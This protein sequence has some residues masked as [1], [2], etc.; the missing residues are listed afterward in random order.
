MRKVLFVTA[1][2][3]AA[4]LVWVSLTLPPRQV[5]LQRTPDGTV[6]GILHVH[7]SRS[8]GRSTPDEIAAAAARA[9]LSFVVF[10]DHGDGTR[11]P[12]PP[13]Y[14]S[15][16]LCVDGVEISTTGGHYIA[17]EMTSAP[18]PLGGEP[19][20]VIDDVRRLG[21]FG[22]VA[23]PDS[24]KAALQWREWTAPFDALEWLNPDTSWRQ[25]SLMPGW[26]SRAA[27]VLALLHYP[28]RPQETI[29]Q[30][31][32]GPGEILRWDVLTRRRRVVALAGV[33]A[34]AKL[35]LRNTD[36]GDNRYTLPLPGY[37]ATFRTLSVHV[38]TE[39][40]LTR[41]A[42]RDAA[43][44]MR[45][46]RAGHAYTAIDA[47]ASPPFFEFSATNDLGTVHEGDELGA[48]GPVT[49]AVR[50][51][52][53]VGFATVIYK[54]G[55]VLQTTTERT[56]S[57]QA[58]PD[59]AVY[60]VEIQTPGSRRS[61]PS[62]WILSNPVYVRGPQPSAKLAD[63]LPPTTASPLPIG[64]AADGWRIENYAGHGT[65]ERS[66]SGGREL[67]LA[68]GLDA[69]PV[70]GQYVA[71]VFDTP[72]GIA[73]N[74]RLV[75]TARAE[76]PM[77]ISV[78]LRVPADGG[79]GERWQRSVYV[80]SFDQERTVYFDDVMP[81]GPTETWKPALDRV[82]SVMFVIDTTNTRPGST[83]RLT[84][85]NVALAQ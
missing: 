34:H 50:S 12:D 77:R 54:D 60:R 76:R 35:A 43:M 67:R 6:A 80:G 51:N 53:P 11:T 45:A 74:D 5:R 1:A 27:L 58:P 17:L 13:T 68:Y 31:L 49:I 39:R 37:E 57:V 33:D 66:S 40:P 14:R 65:L 15:G 30:L 63:R 36:P 41:D 70:A 72:G 82:R 81:I 25:Y 62:R 84:I 38:A 10:T 20:D 85:G 22:I 9:G 71:L 64:D 56:V 4:V 78:Q 61:G 21:G 8:D 42:D 83:G 46:L 18:Y 26:R 2:L 73:P 32:G 79:G 23:H 47:F 44:L 19:R 24:P 48:S 55:R 28:V 7:T 59:P 29:G 75:F 52:A 16:V 69:G 3:A